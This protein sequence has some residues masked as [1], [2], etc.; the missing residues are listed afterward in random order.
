MTRPAF[1]VEATTLSGST[2]ILRDTAIR[3]LRR[4]LS[5]QLVLRGAA[6]YDEA[7]TIW[8]RMIDRRPALIARCAGADD[9]VSAVRFARE[10]DLLLSVRGGGHT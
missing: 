9:V 1:V 2:R 3:E 4:G 7:R 8:N 5:G 10:H 6:G